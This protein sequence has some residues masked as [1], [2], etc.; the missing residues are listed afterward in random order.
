MKYRI[1]IKNM[2]KNCFL[3]FVSIITLA[4]ISGIVSAPPA[5]HNVKGRVFNSDGITGVENGIPVLIY[6]VNNSNSVKTEVY[7]PPIPSLKGAYSA[8]IN[9]SDNDLIN[10]TSWNSTHYGHSS[11]YLLQQQ[12]K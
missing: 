9:S 6:D 8:S 2:S 7:A 4:L 1:R 3:I 11:A 12:R 5:P 10:V